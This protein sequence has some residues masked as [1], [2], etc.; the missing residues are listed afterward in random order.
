VITVY[1]QPSA[2]G[3]ECRGKTD[4]EAA[5]LGYQPRSKSSPQKARM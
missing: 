3:S 1:A 4:S 5:A 2:D